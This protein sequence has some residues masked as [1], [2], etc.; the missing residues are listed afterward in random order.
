MGRAYPG[1]EVRLVDGSGREVAEGE[2]GEIVTSSDSPT[3][4]LG[5]LNN[6]EKESDMKL[7]PYLRTN[8]LAVGMRMD[9]SGTRGDP[10]ILSSLQAFALDRQK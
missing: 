5:Y 10:T 2:I 9:I 6:P 7:G 8:D 3:R 4:F 1:H